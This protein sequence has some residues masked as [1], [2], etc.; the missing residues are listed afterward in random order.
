MDDFWLEKDTFLAHLNQFELHER[1]FDHEE[2]RVIKYNKQHDEIARLQK[3]LETFK[4]NFASANMN[5]FGFIC[6]KKLQ[7][8][9]DNL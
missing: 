8:F 7:K 9:L 5:A 1:L 2:R 4:Q 3:R 6:Y